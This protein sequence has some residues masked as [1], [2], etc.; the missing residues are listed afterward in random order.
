MNPHVHLHL[1]SGTAGLRE[2]NDRVGPSRGNHG[3]HCKE[4]WSPQARQGDWELVGTWASTMP[5][6]EGILSAYWLSQRP[7][8]MLWRTRRLQSSF[9]VRTAPQW[10]QRD[11]EGNSVTLGSQMEKDGLSTG[12]EGLQHSAHGRRIKV[13][14]AAQDLRGL[15]AGPYPEPIAWSH[16]QN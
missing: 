8:V 6:S 14:K 12:P 11:R 2:D 5:H 13:V 9:G 1:N 7:G 3:L 15:S 16:N 10:P 4:E